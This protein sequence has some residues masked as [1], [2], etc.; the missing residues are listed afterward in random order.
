MESSSELEAQAGTLLWKFA[1]PERVLGG[2]ELSLPTQHSVR[3]K[4]RELCPIQSDDIREHGGTAGGPMTIS[5]CA[6]WPSARTATK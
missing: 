3:E 6:R 1:L 4:R 5:P 2:L